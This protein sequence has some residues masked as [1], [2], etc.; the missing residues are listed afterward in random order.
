MSVPLLANA[1]EV[2]G[3]NADLQLSWTPREASLG[4]TA[5]GTAADPQSFLL[6]PSS[7]AELQQ[8]SISLSHSRT[9]LQT[10]YHGLYG[11][12][13]L[14]PGSSL[15]FA[16][17][18]Y[19]SDQIPLVDSGE[20]VVGSNYRTFD[21]HSEIM[22]L[23]YGR[24]WGP[25]DVGL[26][27]NALYRDQIQKGLG[28]RA[29]LSAKYRYKN[30]RLGLGLYGLSSSLARWESEILEYAPP[31]MKLGLGYCL[32]APYF[33]GKFNMSWQSAGMFQK[34]GK[35]IA[36]ASSQNDGSGTVRG[37]R[38]YQD[39]LQW[40]GLSSWGLEYVG[41]S[42]LG[43]AIGNRDLL[44]LSSLAW[45]ASFQYRHW[46]VSYALE[47]HP[48][49]GNTHR[50]GL[51]MSWGESST[52]AVD[53]QPILETPPQAPAPQKPIESQESQPQSTT[54]STSEEILE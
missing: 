8:S 1:L 32:P 15:G 43:L 48:D 12:Y 45:G 33:Y 53:Q 47:E 14:A 44:S 19:S 54:Q 11:T 27:A 31:E 25:L 40:L 34:E 22:R 6:D 18:R 4:Q 17:Q 28:F 36:A 24:Q 7:L 38:F 20:T 10:A 21:L 29:D 39:P 51:S 37:A 42:G 13:L 16:L 49:L 26:I 3:A 23:A 46:Q 52:P 2:R 41:S 5:L 9:L 30:L 50:F 35:G